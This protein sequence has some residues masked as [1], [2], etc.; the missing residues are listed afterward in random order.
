MMRSADIIVSAG[1]TKFMTRNRDRGAPV[2]RAGGGPGVVGRFQAR[3]VEVGVQD[4]GPC[5]IP[6]APPRGEVW[7]KKGSKHV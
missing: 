3:A 1:E 7:E 6:S 5:A 4:R 2:E